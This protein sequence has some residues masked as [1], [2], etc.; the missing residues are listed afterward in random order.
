[1]SPKQGFTT[2][3]R[4]NLPKGDISSFPKHHRGMGSMNPIKYLEYP[5]HYSK[6]YLHL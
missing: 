6:R 2:E 5:S 3:H 1:M 4:G